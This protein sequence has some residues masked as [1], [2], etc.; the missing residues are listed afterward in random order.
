M[1]YQPAETKLAEVLVDRDREA[2]VRATCLNALDLIAS[3]L[4]LPALE[5]AA[6][7][8]TDSLLIKG[9]REHLRKQR[10]KAAAGKER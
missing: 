1:A 3:P 8:E 7:V 9:L 10:E 4:L 2:M 5:K 6:P